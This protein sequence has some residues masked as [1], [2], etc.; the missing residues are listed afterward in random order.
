MATFPLSIML[1]SCKSNT[2]EEDGMEICNL[3]KAAKK[4]M[5]AGDTEECRRISEETVAYGK[6][7]YDK[8]HDDMKTLNE[9]LKY[10]E[11]C[12]D[13]GHSAKP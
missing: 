13:E 9:V 10:G 5:E 12:P 1:F 11:N 3:N 4:A 6:K 2:P 7:M 8:Y